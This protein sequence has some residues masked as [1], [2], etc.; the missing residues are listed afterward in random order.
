[1]V[2][3]PNMMFSL[4]E[5][6]LVDGIRLFFMLYYGVNLHLGCVLML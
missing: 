1:M 4:L 6:E 2:N 5:N 3:L